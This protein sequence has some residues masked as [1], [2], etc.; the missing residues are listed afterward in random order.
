MKR[1]A[2][3]APVQLHASKAWKVFQLSNLD[4]T[5]K[6]MRLLYTLDDCIKNSPTA[7]QNNLQDSKKSDLATELSS[8]IEAHACIDC[9]RKTL[10]GSSDPASDNTVIAWKRIPSLDGKISQSPM[11]KAA[12]LELD[13]PELGELLTRYL[14]THEKRLEFL[15]NNPQIREN[16]YQTVTRKNAGKDYSKGYTR[17][18]LDMWR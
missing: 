16:A 15:K 9:I 14:S 1:V 17:E 8:N 10:D 18:Q 4:G 12:H 7:A 6:I 5:R 11:E 2:Y 3:L 13:Y